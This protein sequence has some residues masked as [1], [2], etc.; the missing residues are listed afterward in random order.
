MNSHDAKSG[1]KLGF[2]TAGTVI[3]GPIGGAIGNALGTL[4]GTFVPEKTFMNQKTVFNENVDANMGYSRK[5]F[6]TGFK[7]YFS[8]EREKAT[9]FSKVADIASDAIPALSG[10]AGFKGLIKTPFRKS[11]GLDRVIPKEVATPKISMSKIPTTF[12]DQIIADNANIPTT[13]SINKIGNYLGEGIGK[14]NDILPKKEDEEFNIGD[15][16]VNPNYK[17][18][19]ES[20]FEALNFD[21]T[22]NNIMG[23]IETSPFKMF[24]ETKINGKVIDKSNMNKMESIP[25][26]PQFKL[27]QRNTSEPNVSNNIN[28]IKSP[29]EEMNSFQFQGLKTYPSIL[30]TDKEYDLEKIRNASSIF[31]PYNNTYFK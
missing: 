29:I 1:L 10:A 9:T 28:P 24:D 11:I 22:V 2:T 6:G 27:K 13:T 31:T 26:R 30:G 4:A 25:Y 18:R 21:K 5:D 14:I 8:E 23:S 16:S 17:S 15:S 12:T 19:V 7:N 20:E 3:G